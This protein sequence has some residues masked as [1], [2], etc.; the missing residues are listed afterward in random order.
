MLRVQFPGEKTYLRVK[1]FKFGSEAMNWLYRVCYMKRQIA[2]I[3]LS[4]L[5]GMGILISQT[6]VAAP[7]YAAS[8]SQDRATATA[9]DY[10]RT[11]AFSLG[12][13]IDQLQ[14]EGY[15]R[16]DS[17]WG[18]N[19]AGADWNKEAKLAAKEYLASQAFS[20]RGLT[21]QLVFDKFTSAQAAYGVANCGANWNAQ[22]VKAAR[23]YLASQ[24]F[25]R[26]GLVQ[27]LVFDGFTQ[28]QA[29]YGV[30]KAY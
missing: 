29:T 1:N 21:Q 11:Q 18:A 20:A 16:A 12:G 19:H 13:L 25:S 17:T 14:F 5:S 23:E 4:V 6:M 15:S 8:R 3:S 30:N 10:L 27:Q 7:A 9:R 28:A 2:K 26:S 24:H 22:A